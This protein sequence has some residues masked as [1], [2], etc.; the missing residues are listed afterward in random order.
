MTTDL[1]PTVQEVPAKKYSGHVARGGPFHPA[2]AAI[3]AK[4]A[5]IEALAVRQAQKAWNPVSSLPG[6][7]AR[8]EVRV[9]A[10]P[11]D[12]AGE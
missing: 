1:N 2:A 11:D 12:E 6:K 5:E 7:R 4:L 10:F 3:N 8:V 9:N